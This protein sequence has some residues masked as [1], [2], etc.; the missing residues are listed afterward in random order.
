MRASAEFKVGATLLLSL[1]LFASMAAALGRVEFRQPSGYEFQ[2]LYKR[3]DG[4]REGAPV[5]FAGVSVGKVTSIELEPGGVRV[6]LRLERE[7]SIPV[8][9]RF[10]IANVGVL[11]DKQLEIQPGKAEDLLSAGTV[12]R[13]VDPVQLDGILSEIEG[14]LVGLN[15]IVDSFAEIIEA[16]ELKESVVQSGVV[17]QETVKSLQTTVD[18]VNA[19][20]LSALSIGEQLELFAVELNKADM[21]GIIGNIEEFSKSL[22]A[23]DLS[24]SV[25]SI[26]SFSERLNAVP[27]EAIAVDLKA[28]SGSLALIDITDSLAQINLLGTRLNTLPIEDIALDLKTFSATLASTDI[29]DTLSEIRTFST[30]LKEIP[31]EEIA[32]DLKSFSGNLALVDVTET[33]DQIHAF[34]AKLS[35]V[36]I[37]EVASDLHTFSQMLAEVDLTK[38]LDELH[39]F[40]KELN[41]L[42][43][44]KVSQDLAEF[45]EGLQQVNLAQIGEDVLGFTAKLKEVDLS[46]L[47]T[48]LTTLAETIHSLDLKTTGENLAVFTENLAEFPLQELASDLTEITS[49]LKVFPIADIGENLRILSLELKDLPISAVVSDLK[50]LTTTLNEAGL[51]EIAEEV[52]VF[53]GQLASL[54]LDT[55]FLE[56]TEDIQSVTK[57]FANLKFSLL[58]EEMQ[59]T[60]STLNSLFKSVEQEKIASILQDLEDTA[61]SAREVSES[62][63]VSLSEIGGSAKDVLALIA[64]AV[65][66]SKEAIA[67][68]DGLVTTVRDFLD[69]VLEDGEVAVALRATLEEIQKTAENINESLEL[70]ITELPLTKE[71]FEGLQNTM[72]SIQKINT[73][74]QNLKGMGEKV[75]IASDW[76]LAYSF[77]SNR[78]M[79]D[80]HFQFDP[81][82]YPGFFLVGWN[83]LGESNLLQLQYGKEGDSLRQRY[84]IIDT[85][86]GVGL[87]GF[88]GDRWVFSAEL[89]DL[90]APKLRLNAQYQWMTDW[91]VTLR[92]NDV[93]RESAGGIIL[94]MKRSF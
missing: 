6:F 39:L 26:N 66:E 14:A 35:Q 47:V 33:M 49:M 48:E 2:V 87:D 27:I 68:V 18:Q 37:D 82:D 29:P 9:S 80:V 74:I 73:D 25:S 23:V 4:L 84:G 79:A 63:G 1:V 69:D 90:S 72:V 64:D 76:G 46:L 83:D 50:T 16:P 71:T 19:L 40:T 7:L 65:E 42:P 20:T 12:I 81:E 55:V 53:T 85:A 41:T 44:R 94:G 5:R 51:G 67:G 24:G 93:F 45:S 88:V 28:F 22:A 61:K 30:R 36:P 62:L 15:R 58:F 21:E 34:G 31:L 10:T 91:W 75:K 78:L 59:E 43:I 38:P 17:M 60:V 86:L 92:A 70:V 89:R 56:I 52:Q 3:V 54:S 77:G 8:D 57:E 11:G 32:L 13:G